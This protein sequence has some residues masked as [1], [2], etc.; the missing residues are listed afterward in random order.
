V[1][2]GDDIAWMQPARRHSA[3]GLIP[4]PGSS[5]SA[6]ERTR[7]PDPNVMDALRKNTI[8]TNTALTS[9]NEPWWRHEDNGPTGVID[10]QGRRGPGS[11]GPGTTNSR[12]TVRRIRRFDFSALGRIRRESRF[13]FLFGGRRAASG[14]AG[15]RSDELAARRLRRRDHGSERLGHDRS[16]GPLRRP[17]PMAMLP[18]CAIIWPIISAIG[19]KMGKRIARPPKN[20]PRNWFRKAPTE[21]SL[22]GLP[23]KCSRLEVD[24]GAY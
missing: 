24:H 16:G 23:R 22:A 9:R 5:A 1:D 8:F 2:V 11:N 13:R 18:F 12:Y 15:V 17:I 21:N 19:L 3:C 7:K 6:L 4:R 20:L 14:A 10:W